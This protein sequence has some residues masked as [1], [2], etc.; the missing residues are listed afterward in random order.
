MI[1]VD[2]PRR[3]VRHD[4]VPD[5]GGGSMAD[6]IDTEGLRLIVLDI[7]KLMTYTINLHSSLKINNNRRLSA[8]F[9]VNHK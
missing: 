2:I 7:S 5:T 8:G 3:P 1:R 4:G 6:E 9:A